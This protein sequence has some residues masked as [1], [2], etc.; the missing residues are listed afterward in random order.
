MP[1]HFAG[2]EIVAETKNFLI[3]CEEDPA[4]RERA[5]FLSYTC[6]ADLTR[7]EQIFST[8]F[9]A[10]ET[11][12]FGTWVNVLVPPPN[13]RPNGFNYGYEHDESSRIVIVNAF[14]P[15]PPEPPS[16]FPPDPRLPGTD[17]NRILQDFARR[18]FV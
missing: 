12:E 16:L 11:H 13:R 15:P 8:K 14:V 4:A 6:E 7:L 9:Q 2:Y 1:N 3:T 10:G 18:I 5:A 17:V